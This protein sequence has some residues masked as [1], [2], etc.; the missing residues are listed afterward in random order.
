M[1][2]VR[3]IEND[4][5]PIEMCKFFKL[6]QRWGVIPSDT[7]RDYPTGRRGLTIYFWFSMLG[8]SG[9]A[10]AVPDFL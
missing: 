8:R 1:R 7:I 4:A 5:I 9:T 10:L 2:T 3:E 6:A